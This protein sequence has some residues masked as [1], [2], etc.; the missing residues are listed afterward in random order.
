MQIQNNSREQQIV[1][2]FFSSMD[3]LLEDL[4]KEECSNLTDPF[5][6][7]WA[8]KSKHDFILNNLFL[9]YLCLLRKN[10]SSE[11]K[12]KIE[13]LFKDIKLYHYTTYETLEKI[14]TGKS[15]KLSSITDMNDKKECEALCEFYKQKYQ[16]SKTEGIKKM[17]SD[18]VERQKIEDFIKEKDDKIKNF[19]KLYSYYTSKIFSFSF[20][21]LKDDAAQWER[22]GVKKDLNATKEPCGICIE[23][24]MS[25][26]M[27]LVNKLIEQNNP[28]QQKNFDLVVIKPILYVPNYDKENSMLDIVSKFAY[29]YND[30]KEEK[31]KDLI[32]EMC[33]WSAT[34]K[35]ESFKKEY[36]I[37]LL[38]ALNLP[39]TVKVN[40]SILLN[41]EQPCYDFGN[42]FS[43]IILGPEVSR[44]MK[45][46]VKKLL[47]DNHIN[48]NDNN[49]S[50]S[51]CPLH[52]FQ[53][54]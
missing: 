38:V 23:I 11:I 18:G 27:D 19:E 39:D 34:I 9:F 48:I 47:E 28:Q 33:Q 45:D 49:I 46:K 29:L 25:S 12:E 21:A 35:H 10:V 17:E 1:T 41:L 24:P 5:F 14:I 26:L 43:S 32:K 53:N 40:G 16:E 15:L 13:T 50:Y 37:R 51:N 52:F 2:S 44:D 6:K 31:K 8:S 36:E 42:L 54:R 30:H 4:N 3:Q 22:Y 7:I 20:S